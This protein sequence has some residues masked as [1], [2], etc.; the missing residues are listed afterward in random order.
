[1]GDYCPHCRSMDDEN[2]GLCSCDPPPPAEIIEANR[3][4]LAI[5]AGWS[6]KLEESRRCFLVDSV[7]RVPVCHVDREIEEAMLCDA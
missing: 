3:R 5:R 6:P 4:R 7:Y 2:H 1:M